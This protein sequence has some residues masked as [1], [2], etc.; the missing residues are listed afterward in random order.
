M[1]VTLSKYVHRWL[2][3]VEENLTFCRFCGTVLHAGFSPASEICTPQ[4][5]ENCACDRCSN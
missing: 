3:F 4:H 1:S 2:H 5:D